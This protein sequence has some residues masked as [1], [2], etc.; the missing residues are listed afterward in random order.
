MYTNQAGKIIA[1]VNYFNILNFLHKHSVV[2]FITHH[3]KNFVLSDWLLS[4]LVFV[5]RAKA[6]SKF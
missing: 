4:P 3:C 1:I 5:I 6:Q 2:H